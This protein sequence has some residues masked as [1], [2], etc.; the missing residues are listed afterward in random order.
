M[1]PQRGE[2]HLAQSCPVMQ[3]IDLTN[4]GANNEIALHL[5]Y[6]HT[7]YGNSTTGGSV[8]ATFD[9][10]TNGAVTSSQSF[11]AHGT[12]FQGE[13]FTQAQLLGQI[14]QNRVVRIVDVAPHQRVL[15]DQVVR[16]RRKVEIVLR[17]AG[18]PHS[19]SDVRHPIIIAKCSVPRI[20]QGTRRRL[21]W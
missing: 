14:L 2:F 7:T 21:G 17:L 18:P 10:L 13:D 3:S 16:D 4:T 19:A 9:L 20:L 1:S 5:N 15:F 8:T 6:D 12:I 11:S